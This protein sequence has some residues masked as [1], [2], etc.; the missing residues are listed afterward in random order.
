MLKMEK[1]II[2][3]KM[4]KRHKETYHWRE[5]TDDKY[6]IKDIHNH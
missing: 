2:Q 3:L 4:G 5:Y 1:E 6:H